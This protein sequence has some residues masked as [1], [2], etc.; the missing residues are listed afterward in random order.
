MFAKQFY[1]YKLSQAFQLS[2]CF[3]LG[4]YWLAGSRLP[5]GGGESYHFGGKPKLRSRPPVLVLTLAASHCRLTVP[6]LRGPF[7]S[8]TSPQTHPSGMSAKAWG[9]GL[10]TPALGVGTRRG[11]PHQ[12]AQRHLPLAR[13]GGS[14]LMPFVRQDIKITFCQVFAWK[15]SNDM[16]RILT[17]LLHAWRTQSI[18]NVS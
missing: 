18:V 11:V 17:E 13:P 2:L 4:A 15:Q 16:T 1:W 6:L 7:G 10:E 14:V 9:H 12:E 8:P 3:P 5:E